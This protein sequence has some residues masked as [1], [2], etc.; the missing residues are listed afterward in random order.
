MHILINKKNLVK[1]TLYDVQT[2]ALFKV[3]NSN[4]LTD[5]ANGRTK[6]TKAFPT[7]RIFN[8][9]LVRTNRRTTASAR[10]RQRDRQLFT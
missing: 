3:T 5:T 8:L 4:S 6:P 10:Q 2:R 7:H 1:T 9:T